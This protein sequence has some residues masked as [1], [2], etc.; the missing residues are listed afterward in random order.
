MLELI[1]KQYLDKEFKVPCYMEEPTDPPEEYILIEKLGGSEKN[2][3]L[4]GILAF[5]SY[6]TSLY[7]AA[8]LNEELKKVLKNMIVLDSISKIRL[9]SDYN[10]TDPQTKRYRYQAVYDFYYYDN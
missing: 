8:Q 10:F 4:N 5:Q 6:S 1:A 7:K 3:L 2:Q 9:N